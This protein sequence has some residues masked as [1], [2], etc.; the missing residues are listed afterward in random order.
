[1]SHTTT[2]NCY[3]GRVKVGKCITPIPEA[4]RGCRHTTAENMSRAEFGR[5][6]VI[7]CERCSKAC[8]RECPDCQ[9][10]Y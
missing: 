3:E 2:L 1:M 4:N 7:N 8:G 6:P 5:L 10:W 9:R